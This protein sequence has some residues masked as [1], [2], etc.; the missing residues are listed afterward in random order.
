MK[1]SGSEK[2]L[3]C[4][5]LFAGGGGLS[6]GMEAAG[7]NVLL[8][9]DIAESSAQTFER[10]RPEIPFIRKDVRRIQRSEVDAVIAGRKVDLVIGGP[11]CQGFS[12]IGDQLQGDVRNTLFASM[13]RIVQWTDADAFL[14][15]NVAYLRSQYGG[16]YEHEIVEAFEALGFT[17]EVATLNAADYGVPQVRQRVLFFGTRLGSEFSWPAPTHSEV[18]NGRPEWVT[19]GQA[20]MD[21]PDPESPDNGVPNHLALRHSEKVI[22]RYM[23]IPEGGRLPPP[24]ELP[25]EIRRKNFGNTYKRLHRER[26]SLTLVPGNNAFPVHPTQPRSLTPRE[27]ARLQTFPDDY[28]FLGNRAEQCRLVGNAVPV[29]LAQ[30]VGR[31]VAA[32]LLATRR[33]LSAPQA[34][35][36]RQRERATSRLR[37]TRTAGKAV[38]F[39][40]G[41][42]GLMLGFMNAGFDVVASL[43]RKSIVDRNTALNFPELEHVHQDLNDMTRGDIEAIAERGPIDVVFGGSPCQGFSIFG[44]RRFV[45]TKG[46]R[47]EDDERNE[48]TP[49]F[50]R[51]AIELEP[52]MILLENVKGLPSTR[53]GD[54]TYLEYIRSLLDDAGYRSDW[55]ILNCADYGVPQLRER[56]VLVASQPDIEFRWPEPKFFSEPRPWQKPHVTVGDVISD[57]MD[58]STVDV[59]FSHVPM[60]HKPLVVERYKLI[61][62]GGRLPERDLPRHLV[63]GYRSDNIKNFSHVYRRLAMDRP[64]TTMVPGH[65]AFPVHPRLPRTLTVREAAR[66]QTFP[67]EIRFVGTRQQQCM[68]V[69]NAVPPLLA[70]ILAQAIAKALDHVYGDPGYKRDIY[71]LRTGALVTQ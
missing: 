36:I 63:K 23:L 59:E 40:T 22:Q 53:R 11:P 1:T 54:T 44:N 67:D 6:L 46:H 61:P 60:Q 25:P 7:F 56:F 8:A 57:L 32:H 17:V 41:A 70:S 64:A 55:R 13:K 26:P 15:E 62:E 27:A 43:D 5:A 66:I 4:I 20:I 19:V 50:I 58:E 3:N 30:H 9:T 12:T 48:L 16:R 51:R 69:G 24:S 71:D 47:P 10:N 14:M 45:N 39:F 37:Q 28:V 18:L 34:P 42:G 52:R 31:A 2:T 38:S 21:L 35:R 29:Q 49:A 68:L 33:S 65:N